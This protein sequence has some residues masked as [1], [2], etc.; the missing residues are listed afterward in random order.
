[1]LAVDPGQDLPGDA[2]DVPAPGPAAQDDRQE[3]RVRDVPGAGLEQALPDV[4]LGSVGL[5]PYLVAGAFRHA[6]SSRRRPGGGPGG[7]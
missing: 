1:M 2:P 6:S 7:G 3:I 4:G 5:G